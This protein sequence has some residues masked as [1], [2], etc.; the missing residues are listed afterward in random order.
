M[1]NPHARGWILPILQIRINRRS[2]E[3]PSIDKKR[4]PTV[5]ELQLGYNHLK[6]YANL[7]SQRRLCGFLI[8][9]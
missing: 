1:P 8:G 2:S 7:I 9:S 6:A 3:I 4:Q 5:A